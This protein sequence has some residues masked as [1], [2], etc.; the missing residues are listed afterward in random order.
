MLCYSFT[1]TMLI[2]ICSVLVSKHNKADIS[3]HSYYT[4]TL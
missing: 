3:I 4:Y 1:Y 2:E